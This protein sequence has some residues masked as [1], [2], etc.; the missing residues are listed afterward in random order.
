MCELLL[1]SE[2]TAA[3]LRS[4]G[5]LARTVSIKVRFADFATITRSRTVDVPA[6]ETARVLRAFAEGEA[7][8][9]LGGGVRFVRDG[10]WGWVCPDERRPE[11]RIV[12]ESANAE[13]ARELCDFCERKLKSLI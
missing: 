12:A 1:L 3:R 13:F 5:W 4:G 6:S 10:G 9:E 8:T 7:Q 2:R 11:F